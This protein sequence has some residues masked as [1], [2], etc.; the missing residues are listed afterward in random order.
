MSG[1]DVMFRDERD[2]VNFGDTY[3]ASEAFKVLF[4]EG[5]TMVEEAAAYLDGVG[6]EE[7]R[8]MSRDGTLNY[9]SESM[10]LTTRLMQIASWLLVQRAVSEGELTPAEAM[11]EKTRVRLTTPETF[12]AEVFGVLPATLQDLIVRS[13]RLHTRIVHLD[14]LITNDRPTPVAVESPVAAQQGLLRSAF[15]MAH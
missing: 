7:S 10:R 9:S 8:L 12:R 2:W 13:R 14:A 5:M 1:F 4:R 6:R 3:V 11:Q 15:G